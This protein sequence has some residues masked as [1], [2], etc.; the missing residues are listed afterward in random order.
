[1]PLL[2]WRALAVA[3][4]KQRARLLRAISDFERDRASRR[5]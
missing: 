3:R 1:M 4:A 2:H 5:Y